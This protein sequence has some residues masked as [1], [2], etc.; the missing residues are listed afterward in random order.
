VC[1]TGECSEPLS[2]NCNDF[3]PDFCTVSSGCVAVLGG[4]QFETNTCGPPSNLCNIMIKDPNNATCCVEK[5]KECGVSDGCTSYSCNE[6]DGTCVSTPLCVQGD[7]LCALTA[8]VDSACVSTNKTCTSP[9]KCQTTTCDSSTGLCTFSPV[10]CDDHN[11]CTIDICSD[12]LGCQFDPVICPSTDNCSISSCDLL[13]GGCSLEKKNCSDDVFCTDDKCDPVLGCLKNLNHSLCK[14]NNTCVYGQCTLTGCVFLPV[15]DPCANS[16]LNSSFC[17]N[18]T[19]LDYSGCVTLP[20]DCK[21]N[22]SNLSCAIYNC[23]DTEEACIKIEHD[24]FFFFGVVAGALAGGVIAAI[25]VA[26]ILIAF[27]VTGGSAYAVS[28]VTQEA[29]VGGITVN[30]LYKGAKKETINPLG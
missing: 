28:Q 3:L 16:S 30:P 7:D 2:I 27:G 18:V 19:C 29:E 1:I 20:R 17:R 9:S 14:D 25:V 24:C 12:T 22:N 15:I 8:C 21:N 4:C 26:G 23:S 5:P 10:D 6:T 11:N 13:T